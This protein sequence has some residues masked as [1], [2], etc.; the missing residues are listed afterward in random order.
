ME[1]QTYDN[2]SAL[3]ADAQALAEQ[4]RETNPFVCDI[5]L[6]KFE[7][8][9]IGKDEEVLYATA[10]NADT[11]ETLFPLLVCRTSK[12]RVTKIRSMTNFYTTVFTPL[13]R[14]AD[15]YQKAS[16]LLADY[17]LA[18][19][20]HVV[21]FEFEPVRD[22]HPLQLLAQGYSNRGS[23]VWRTYHKHINRYE[24]VLGDDFNDYLKRRPSQLRNT[25]RRK[26]KLLG[27][28]T[29]SEL[30]IYAT[31]DEIAQHYSAF[32]LIYE[33]SWKEEES[34]PD[35]I[36]DVLTNLA[37]VG[38]AKLAVL[39][40]DGEPAAAQIWFKIGGGWGVFK[41]AYRPKYKR[42]SV[43]TLLT[44]GVIEG[45]LCDRKTTE[46]DFFSGDDSYKRDWVVSQREHVGIELLNTKT[47]TG[48]ALSLKRRLSG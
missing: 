3:P 25:I 15:A 32:R 2:F 4:Y 1:I 21:M 38:I 16:G 11:C 43:G 10:M 34:H 47:L 37:S 14:T 9:L 41:L 22:A 36:G 18:K 12:L 17:L 33:E 23:G 20:P 29:D 48:R 19:Y 45:L 24:A 26:N 5:W 40:V 8:Y 46:I 27:K 28:E 39:S 31:A 13:F 35:F 6:Q 7:Q 30:N 42:Y 44:A